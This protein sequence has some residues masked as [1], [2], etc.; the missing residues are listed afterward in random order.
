[1]VNHWLFNGLGRALA[2]A[3]IDRGEHVF[4]SARK[5]QELDNLVSGHDNAHAPKLDVTASADVK[6]VVADVK[7][8]GG[9]DVLVNNAGYGY[10]ARHRERRRGSVPNGSGNFALTELNRILDLPAFCRL[11]ARFL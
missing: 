4:A 1:L 8:Q 9:I 10:L 2:E 11:L 5:P 3:L 7:R 6:K